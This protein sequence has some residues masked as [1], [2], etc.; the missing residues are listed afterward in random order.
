MSN[1]TQEHIE[2]MVEK[3]EKITKIPT[4]NSIRIEHKMPWNDAYVVFD[5]MLDNC[6]EDIKIVGHKYSPSRA[7]KG[8]DPIAYKEAML[9]HF[10]AEMRDGILYYDDDHDQVFYPED[11]ENLLNK[12][13]EGLNNEQKNTK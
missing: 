9:D 2:E 6:Y 13:T 12:L 1:Y 7:L 4:W 10:D 11:L 5:D 8:V 3:I